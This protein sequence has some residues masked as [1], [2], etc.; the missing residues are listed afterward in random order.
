MGYAIIL[1]N[2]FAF[3]RQRGT[4]Q[5]GFLLF[6]GVVV[7]INELILKNL[8]QQVR[9]EHSCLTS[10]GMPSG[11]S[12]LAMGFF[13]VMILDLIYRV[14][15]SQREYLDERLLAHAHKSNKERMKDFYRALRLQFTVTPLAR[16]TELSINELLAS[17]SCW[18][19][20]LL[21]V[22]LSRVAIRDHTP[23]QVL[24]GS[25]FGCVEGAF[26]ALA[27]RR[28]QF[29]FLGSLGKRYPSEDRCEAR[30]C[31]FKMFFMQH[32]LA[33]PQFLV[34]HITEMDGCDPEFQ[35]CANDAIENWYI[36]HNVE[37]AVATEFHE[38]SNAV[39]TEFHEVENAVATELPKVEPQV[40]FA[41]QLTA[42]AEMANNP[43]TSATDVQKSAD[44]NVFMATYV[45]LAIA[46]N[47]RSCI[48]QRNPRVT[49]VMVMLKSR[50]VREVQEL[51]MTPLA[52][53]VIMDSYK[54]TGPCPLQLW[55]QP[56]SRRYDNDQT[57]SLRAWCEKI[58][59]QACHGRN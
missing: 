41:A 17:V 9:P 54:I 51:P 21:P 38:V 53:K 57:E 23:T 22:P 44:Y 3:V 24:V 29:R 6:A 11:H 4:R 14:N 34:E 36:N 56:P 47:G 40:A 45:I 1:I 12:T 55:L 13:T 50:L 27:S 10:C 48:F 18:C 7:L 30:C 37:N 49:D 32:N 43:S 39:A 28:L 19:V 31:L 5:L 20:I 52:K 26:W 25:F 59:L 35:K 58:C 16:G 33:L 15:P 46:V 8:F 42:L 2:G